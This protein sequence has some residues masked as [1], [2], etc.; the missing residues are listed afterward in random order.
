MK[1]IYTTNEELIEV[2][3]DNGINITC[4]ENMNMIISDEDSERIGEIVKEFA[5]AALMDYSMEDCE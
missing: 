1:I 4:N 5:P 2:L 3:Q